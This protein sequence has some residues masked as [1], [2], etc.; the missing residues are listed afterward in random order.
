MRPPRTHLDLDQRGVVVRVAESTLVPKHDPLD[1][2][3]RLLLG[4]T[5][6]E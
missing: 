4:P 2:E 5:R 3:S 6:R 1:V